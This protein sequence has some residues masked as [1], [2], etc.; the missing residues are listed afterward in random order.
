MSKSSIHVMFISLIELFSI[1]LIL[2]Y[3]FVKIT[4]EKYILFI[5]YVFNYLNKTKFCIIYKQVFFE[6]PS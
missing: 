2:L 1:K 5:C 4:L 3:L 6:I